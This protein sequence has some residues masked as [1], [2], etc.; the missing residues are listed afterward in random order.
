MS[1]NKV[2]AIVHKANDLRTTAHKVSVN[3]VKAID[4]KANTLRT[5]ANKA[6]VLKATTAL[7]LSKANKE[8]NSREN[9]K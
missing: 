5:T 3:K 8:T 7:N 2:K 9:K 6:S 1:V 4:L